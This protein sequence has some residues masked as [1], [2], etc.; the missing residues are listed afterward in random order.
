MNF[1]S[2]RNIFCK[3]LH[4]PYRAEGEGRRGGEGAVQVE[5]GG[6]GKK[7][8]LAWETL[9]GKHFN[10]IIAKH[11]YSTVHSVQYKHNTLL[12]ALM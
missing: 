3:G 9:P 1:F 5:G 8:N 7:F 6:G 12:T 2:L 10:F 11:I 4:Q